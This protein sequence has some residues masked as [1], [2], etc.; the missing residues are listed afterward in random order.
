MG[1]VLNGLI[2]VVVIAAIG[3][4][5]YFCWWCVDGRQLERME[6]QKKHVLESLMMGNDNS[7]QVQVSCK[8]VKKTSN[9]ASLP[10]S[11]LTLLAHLL[12]PLYCPKNP[13]PLQTSLASYSPP[14]SVS[15]SL[16]S[17]SSASSPTVEA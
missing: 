10:P 12:L 11:S 7:M 13:T 15:L 2:V 14:P 6:R 5:A 4:V 16:L 3:G 1:A 17:T 8:A 9:S